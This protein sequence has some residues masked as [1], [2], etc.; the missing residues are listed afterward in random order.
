MFWRWHPQNLL[1]NGRVL[2]PIVPHRNTTMKVSNSLP[3]PNPLKVV[4]YCDIIIL[5]T[6]DT[7]KRSRPFL[8]NQSEP[9]FFGEILKPY[10]LPWVQRLQKEMV[11]DGESRSKVSGLYF[12]ALTHEKKL[13]KVL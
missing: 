2:H 12:I 13:I 4:S 5:W 7:A 11:Q 9:I 3:Q 6:A 8:R 10:L 1:Q